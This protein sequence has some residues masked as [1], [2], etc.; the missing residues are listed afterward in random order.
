MD[1]GKFDGYKKNG[2]TEHRKACAVKSPASLCAE[3]DEYFWWDEVHPTTAAHKYL[4][5]EMWYSMQ[6]KDSGGKADGCMDTDCYGDSIFD[7]C[8]N[9]ASLLTLNAM[10]MAVAMMLML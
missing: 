2:F 7:K 4:A 5:D 1:V 6:Q 3:P 10:W 8:F 9:V